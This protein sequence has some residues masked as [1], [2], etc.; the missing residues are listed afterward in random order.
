MHHSI[1][2]VDHKNASS[3]RQVTSKLLKPQWGEPAIHTFQL[4]DESG[5]CLHAGYAAVGKLIITTCAP[6]HIVMSLP[7]FSSILAFLTEAHDIANAH[8]EGLDR[9]RVA[10]RDAERW[11]SALRLWAIAQENAA[12]VEGGSKSAEGD[13]TKE[14]EKRRTY[15]ERVNDLES[16]VFKFR[17]SAIRDGRHEFKK[18]DIYVA[19]GDAVCERFGEDKAIV[20]LLKYE[21]EVSPYL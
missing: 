15:L 9:I 14:V 10:I 21:L 5:G 11:E 17:A 7:C 3:C 2:N 18:M 19:A 8:A 4:L 20:N 12:K 1:N 16:L 13:T 6:I